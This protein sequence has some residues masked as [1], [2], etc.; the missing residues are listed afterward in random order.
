MRRDNGINA[1]KFSSGK[2]TLTWYNCPILSGQKWNNLALCIYKA[3]KWIHSLSKLIH[4]Y[5]HDESWKGYFYF[6]YASKCSV[7]I[8][9][10]MLYK[11]FIEI[12]RF[13]IYWSELDKH[14]QCN[15]CR[16]II[17][18]WSWKVPGQVLTPC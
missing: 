17:T 4:M 6:N 3:T 13:T 16:G 10:A 2:V 1:K 7:Q 8:I 18:A 15:A 5:M 11:S 9:C 12:Y 14:S